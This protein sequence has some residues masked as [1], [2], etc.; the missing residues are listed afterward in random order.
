MPSG[1]PCAVLFDLDG[2]LV[3]SIGLIIASARHAF[4]GRP[5]PA[6]TEQQLRAGIGRPLAAQFSPWLAGDGDLEF[7]VA[8]YREYQL[9]HHDRLTSTYQG[10]LEAVRVLDDA[11]YPMG[12]VT[13]KIEVMARR[14]LTHVGLDRY[15]QVVVALEAT[16]RHKPD[17][18]PVRVALEQLGAPA[19]RAIFVG[20]S[21][22]DMEA[23][24]AAGVKTVGVTWGP[25]SADVL[26]DAG[27]HVVIDHPADLPWH[28]ASLGAPEAGAA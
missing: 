17:P 26:R 8:R 7:L 4:S 2:T 20:D 14:A 16:A 5:G 3:D 1:P 24:R 12:V 10:I 15:M 25:Y 27:A 18:E 23:G 9:E 19:W 21:P 13:S 11:A 28:V 6:P 22:Y